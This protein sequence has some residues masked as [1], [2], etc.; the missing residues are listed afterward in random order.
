[1]GANR[2]RHYGRDA[3]RSQLDPDRITH[4]IRG[5]PRGARWPRSRRGCTLLSVI[6]TISQGAALQLVRH[7]VRRGVPV[8]RA[9]G[10]LRTSPADLEGVRRYPAQ[11]VV[12][13]WANLRDELADAAVGVRAAGEWRLADLGLFGFCVAAAPTLGAALRFVV[14]QGALVSS[15][16]RWVARGD[17]AFVWCRPGPSTAESVVGDDVMVAGFAHGVFEL[18]GERPRRIELAHRPAQRGD[19]ASLLGCEVRFGAERNAVVLERGLLDA[20]PARACEPLWRYLLRAARDELTALEEG[21]LAERVQCAV[22]GYLA[23]SGRRPRVA[24]VARDLGVGERTLRRHLSREGVSFRAAC[25]RASLSHAA[26]LLGDAT[27]SCTD[28]ALAAGYA[29]AS[30]FSRAWRRFYGESPSRSRRR[31][32]ERAP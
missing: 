17:A 7:A 3:S 11:I 20:A 8:S 24:E 15:G 10:W 12:G 16:G 9:S 22:S 29:D 30:A 19:Y 31:E 25:S 21:S 32:R 4:S 23:R 5:A 26:S 1:M 28:A 2:M 13:A 14:E 18:T 6:G 27:R